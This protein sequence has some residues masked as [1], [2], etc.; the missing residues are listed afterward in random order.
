MY[1]SERDVIFSP[2]NLCC[3]VVLWM[4][5]KRLHEQT[6]AKFTE[7]IGVPVWV[8]SWQ[9]SKPPPPTVSAEWEN[10]SNE[11]GQRL[12]WRLLTEGWSSHIG[13]ST[14]FMHLSAL[15]RAFG[16]HP[17]TVAVSSF[18]N[19]C[20]SFRLWQFQH[21]SCQMSIL[22]G[23]QHMGKECKLLFGYAL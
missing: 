12:E 3:T 11:H 7:L 4:V 14:S 18:Q 23:G 9:P 21:V 19:N 20:D 13:T 10:L 8:E 15:K 17:V 2:E 6:S 5:S 16:N 22:V 1:V